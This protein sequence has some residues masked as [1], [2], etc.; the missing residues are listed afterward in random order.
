V[1]VFGVFLDSRALMYGNILTH[2]RPLQWLDVE[3]WGVRKGWERIYE[4]ATGIISCPGVR[5]SE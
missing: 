2:R 3:E 1:I 5:T 4:A